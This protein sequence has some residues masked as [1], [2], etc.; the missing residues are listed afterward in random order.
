VAEPPISP[1]ACGE[2]HESEIGTVCQR[3]A[4]GTCEKVLQ[5]N[6]AAPTAPTP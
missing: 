5:C 1:L 2:G 6:G 4:S 3:S